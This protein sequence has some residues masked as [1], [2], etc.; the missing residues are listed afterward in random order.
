MM[1]IAMSLYPIIPQSLWLAL[2]NWLL[3]RLHDMP[4]G[5]GL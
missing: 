4:H 2:W 1:H 5:R 3:E